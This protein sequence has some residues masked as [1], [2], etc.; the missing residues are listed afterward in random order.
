MLESDVQIYDLVSKYLLVARNDK[1]WRQTA[2]VRNDRTD[3]RVGKEIVR[4]I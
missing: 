2:E 4:R 1:Q 3:K